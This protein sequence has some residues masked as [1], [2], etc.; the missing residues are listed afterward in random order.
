MGA[1]L[2][3]PAAAPR[4]VFW[5]EAPSLFFCA[6]RS[7]TSSIEIRSVADKICGAWTAGYASSIVP[8]WAESQKN[9]YSFKRWLESHPGM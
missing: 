5:G 9:C 7:A 2:K 4:P 6:G 1:A 3:F 8:L